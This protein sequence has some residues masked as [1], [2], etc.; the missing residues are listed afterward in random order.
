MDPDP[1]GDEAVLPAGTNLVLPSRPG[2]H[3]FL[4]VEGV[5]VIEWPD[6]TTSRHGPGSLIGAADANGRPE[7]LSDVTVRLESPARLL[8]Y[9]TERLAALIDSD[10][11]A[12]AAWQ[13]AR[14]QPRSDA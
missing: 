8:V 14:A 1:G 2:R 10:S 9:E 7:P 6:G 3:C 5:A 13:A 4:V 12:R 11:A